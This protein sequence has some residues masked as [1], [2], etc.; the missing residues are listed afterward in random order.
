M[1]S[2]KPFVLN[3]SNVA[4]QKSSLSTLHRE[5]AALV[6]LQYHDRLDFVLRPRLL[7]PITPSSNEI[8]K[9]ME[10]YRLNEPQAKA[11]ISSLKRDG[12]SLIQG[13]VLGPLIEC[14]VS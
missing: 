12:F 2:G 9:A 14:S 4:K 13:Y 6:S 3:N 10:A 11:I 5:Y 1:S 8:S 7:P